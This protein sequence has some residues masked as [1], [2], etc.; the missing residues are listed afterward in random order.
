M[1]QR[2]V[3]RQLHYF[4]VIAMAMSTRVLNQLRRVLATMS[5]CSPLPEMS[6]IAPDAVSLPSQSTRGGLLWMN[7]ELA[8]LAC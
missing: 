4:S 8:S 2:A 5:A 1:G 7:E 6:L 3:A